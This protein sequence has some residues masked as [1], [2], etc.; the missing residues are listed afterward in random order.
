MSTGLSRSRHYVSESNTWTIASGRCSS[1]FQVVTLLQDATIFLSAL[2]SQSG[3]LKNLT[4]DMV[5]TCSPTCQDDHISRDI[6]D[7]YLDLATTIGFKDLVKELHKPSNNAIDVETVFGTPFNHPGCLSTTLANSGLDLSRLNNVLR[8]LVQDPLGFLKY[9]DAVHETLVERDGRT[10]CIFFGRSFSDWNHKQYFRVSENGNAITLIPLLKLDN[11]LK[12]P[13]NIRSEIIKHVTQCGSPLSYQKTITFD[14]DKRTCADGSSVLASV[15]R[16]LRL[17]SPSQFQL[18]SKCVIKTAS[19]DK[20]TNFERFCKLE[21]FWCIA[22]SAQFPW[23]GREQYTL[24]HLDCLLEVE[25]AT[26]LE[27]L[28]INILDFLHITSTVGSKKGRLTISA[29]RGQGEAPLNTSITFNELRW[30]VLIALTEFTRKHP[31]A[32][33][34]LC[35]NIWIN[36]LGQVIEIEST[37]TTMDPQEYIRKYTPWSTHRRAIFR[38]YGIPIRDGF[39]YSRYTLPAEA[40]D[41]SARF[42]IGWLQRCGLG[43][44]PDHWPDACEL[45]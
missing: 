39:D 3:L 28:R 5:G 43:R 2:C 23:R 19:K 21:K 30:Y 27:S 29:M 34:N 42:Y 1:R 20:R 32:N 37:D 12:L 10:G 6:Q 25:A 14:L 11:I 40:F 24:Q 41:G 35:V 15:C 4:I 9:G 38:G 17:E 7:S 31:D 8:L 13:R 44:N 26:I 22:R 33:R 36:D 18:T 16:K 45:L